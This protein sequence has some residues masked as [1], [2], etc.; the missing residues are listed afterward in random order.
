LQRVIQLNPKLIIPAHGMPL[1]SVSRLQQTLEHRKIREKQVLDLY[2]KGKSPQQMVKIIYPH[3][4]TMLQRLALENIKS[5]LE[6]LS[7]EG[8]L[9]S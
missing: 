3:I 2:Q 8:K 5:H 1:D 4:N 7:A 9:H 6:K